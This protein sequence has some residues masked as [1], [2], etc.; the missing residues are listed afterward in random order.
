MD[1]PLQ[2]EL[3]RERA[4]FLTLIAAMIR[5]QKMIF[6]QHFCKYWFIS[7]WS[8]IS[9]SVNIKHFFVR[10]NSAGF[11]VFICENRKLPF[12]WLKHPL[13]QHLFQEPR[14]DCHAT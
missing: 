6:A 14:M 10:L 3:G 13:I 1:I 2:T 5:R 4:E 12:L 9:I 8:K 11:K 7:V